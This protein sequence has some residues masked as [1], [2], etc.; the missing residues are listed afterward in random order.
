[1]NAQYPSKSGTDLDKID[2]HFRQDLRF[3]GNESTSCLNRESVKIIEYVLGCR[4]GYIAVLV[5][6][7]HWPTF[8]KREPSISDYTRPPNAAN[9]GLLCL[10]ESLTA[11]VQLWASMEPE[12]L[13]ESDG[14]T[15]PVP[16]T[17]MV[18]WISVPETHQYDRLNQYKLVG[19]VVEIIKTLRT[20][21]SKRD[22]T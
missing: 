17:S 20:V 13:R 1:M 15:N 7:S 18:L 21:L 5:M 12:S 8:R 22:R 10:W 19:S 14:N 3:W 9:Q 4:H 2:P 16:C 6:D 11:I